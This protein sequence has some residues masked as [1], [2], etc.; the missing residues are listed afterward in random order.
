MAALPQVTKVEIAAS[1]KLRV[2]T[3]DPE[4]VP[5]LLERLFHDRLPIA[6]TETDEAGIVDLYLKA[7]EEKK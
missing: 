1:A 5:A 4:A 3:T 6:A 2:T 7:T